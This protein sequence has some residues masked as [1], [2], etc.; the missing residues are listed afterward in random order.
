M[1]LMQAFLIALSMYSKI[2]VPRAEW[3]EKNM[4]YAMCFFPV[5]GVVTGGCVYLAGFFLLRFT[6]CGSVFSGAV[7]TLVPILISGGIHLD[8][9]MDTTDA[10]SSYGDREKKLSILK[11]PH[12]GAFAILGM[13]CYLLWSVA[14]YSEVK[15]EM[16]P[17]LSCMFVLS[18]ALSGFSVVTFPAAKDSGLLRT[19]QDK[20]Q[21][22][23][24]RIVMLLW[25]AAALLLLIWLDGKTGG[26]AALCAGGTF[27]YYGWMSKKKFGGITGDL[28]GYFLS[29]CEVC[30]ATGIV[31]AG[32]GI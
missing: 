25:A 7:L 22:K 30:M 18:R 11:D 21:K 29:L 31:L 8:G 19:F 5:V 15:I 13:G 10:L 28:A 32:G 9:F 1:R 24:V 23:N 4:K 3:N 26:M 17:S 12:T 14:V 6:S 2:P 20:A 16:L 27:L